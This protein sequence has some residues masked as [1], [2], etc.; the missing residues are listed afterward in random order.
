[1]PVGRKT[2]SPPRRG[3]AVRGHSALAREASGCGEIRTLTRADFESRRL[4]LLGYTPENPPPPPTKRERGAAGPRPQ[5]RGRIPIQA[6]AKRRQGNKGPTL[7]TRLGPTPLPSREPEPRRSVT[8]P[9]LGLTPQRSTRGAHPRQGLEHAAQRQGQ[10]TR[11]AG[12]PQNHQ[13]QIKVG[14]QAPLA[15]GR[16]QQ[17]R[18]A[19]A[20]PTT[21][22]TCCLGSCYN[23]L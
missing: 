23:L 17:P 19:R 10:P 13:G 9:W 5:H 1:M 7:I 12:A 11:L 8:F 16:S 20:R 14:P 22:T 2:R 21:L 6:V 3:S 18:L 15:Q 4:C